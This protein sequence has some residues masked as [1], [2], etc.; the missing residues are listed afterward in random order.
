M[1]TFTRGDLSIHY[2]VHG[3]GPAVLLF[4][5]G[6]MRSAIALWERA[7]FHPVRELSDRFRVIAMDQRNAGRSRAPVR[8]SDDWRTYAE[9][10]LALLDELGVARCSVFGMCIGGAF[11]LNLAVAAP[12]RV[13]AAVLEQP[14]GANGTNRGAFREIFESWANDLMSNPPELTRAA[15]GGLWRDL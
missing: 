3:S 4:A 14:I 6:G 10:H 13:A 15:G 9:D 12:D 8:A 11:C 5:P 1:P 7:P 2:E